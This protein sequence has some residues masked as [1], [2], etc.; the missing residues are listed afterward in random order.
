MHLSGTAAKRESDGIRMKSAGTRHTHFSRKK[1]TSVGRR[2]RRSKT[3]PAERER[4]DVGF[5]WC[6]VGQ[7][8]FLVIN[9]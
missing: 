6:K 5:Y 3:L 9:I 8:W 2:D 4:K 1:G 7:E